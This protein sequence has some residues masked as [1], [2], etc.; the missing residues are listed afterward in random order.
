VLASEPGYAERARAIQNLVRD[1][2]EIVEAGALTDRIRAGGARIAFHPPCTLQ[3]GQRLAGRIEA[4]LEGLGWT[5][6]D[7]ADRHLCCGSAGSYSLFHAK[8]ADR[9]R[10]DKLEKLL[11]GG[12]QEIVTA[13]IGCQLHLGADAPLAVRHWLELL[14]EHLEPVSP[15]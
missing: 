9:L 15:P 11:R 14:A 1:P 3:H 8:T 10:R 13:N 2:V 4:L 5:L 7:V 6:T 12:P